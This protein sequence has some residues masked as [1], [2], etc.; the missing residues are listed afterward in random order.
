MYG[1]LT[2][3]TIAKL[4]T[5]IAAEIASGATPTVGTATTAKVTAAMNTP[6]LLAA[7]NTDRRTLILQNAGSGTLYLVAGA[8][9]ATT[10]GVS[11][12]AGGSFVIEA[13]T[14]AWYGISPAAL[15]V[16]IVE[17]SV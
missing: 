10:D 2:G 5:Q 7:A 14:T 1:D 4:A 9:P 16:R 8:G 15:D 3:D 13:E 17:V 12:A 11:I 6:Q